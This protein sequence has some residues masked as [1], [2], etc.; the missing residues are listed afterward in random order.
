MA[1]PAGRPPGPNETNER[2]APRAAG[3]RIAMPDQTSFLRTD[4]T[5]PSNQKC[6]S[7]QAMNGA[8]ISR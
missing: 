6:N 2:N 7:E 3:A 1:P 5:K 8:R 4:Q